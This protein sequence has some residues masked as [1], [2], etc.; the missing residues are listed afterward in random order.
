[1]KPK[2]VVMI[3]ATF[4]LAILADRTYLYELELR[5]K[6][7]LYDEFVVSMNKELPVLRKK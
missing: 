2:I 5:N 7:R 3:A 6:A 4:I 1:M